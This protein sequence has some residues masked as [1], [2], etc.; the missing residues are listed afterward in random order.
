MYYF[1]QKNI[2]T[3]LRHKSLF[4]Y[5]KTLESHIYTTRGINYLTKS[6]SKDPRFRITLLDNDAKLVY[7]SEQKIFIPKITGFSEHNGRFFYSDSIEHPNNDHIKYV[8]VSIEGVQKLLHQ[9]SRSIFL[10]LLFF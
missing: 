6:L 3:D 9:V 8:I 4:Y 10:F 1:Y 7:S 2:F 5:T